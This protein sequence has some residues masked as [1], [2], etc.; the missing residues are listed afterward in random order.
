LSTVEDIVSQA[1][2][3][4]FTPFATKQKRYERNEKAK[5]LAKEGIEKVPAREEGA[6]TS[7]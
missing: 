7:G 5:A 1:L 3:A 2:E 4:H 6:T